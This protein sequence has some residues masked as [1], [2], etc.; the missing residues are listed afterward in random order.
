MDRTIV[1]PGALPQDTDVLSAYR[2]AMVGLG[3]L[4]A[5]TLG[6]GTVVDGLGISAST[7][8]DMNVHIAPGTIAS[9]SSV[10]ATAYGAL[11]SNAAPLVKMGINLT[12]TVLLLTAPG[13]AGQSINY[14]IQATFAETDSNA[15]VQPYYNASNPA[16]PY[17]GPS[18][19]GA[20][21]NT[22]RT[23]RVTVALKPGVAAATGSQTTPAV[24]AGYT[25]LYVVTIAN[26]QTT[27]TTANLAN[28]AIATAP[29]IPFKL[30]T[31]MNPGFSRMTVLTAGGTFIAPGGVT[32]IKVRLWAGGG[33]GGA[34]SGASSAASGGAGGG[35]A[36]GIYTVTPG[37]PG[38]TATV[39]AAGTAGTG[40]SNGGAGGPSSFGSLLSAT[41]GG[42][43]FGSAGA[44]Q[45]TAPTGGSG[46]G[47]QTNI[48]GQGGGSG[49]SA[50][51]S[52]FGGSAGGAFS[53]PGVSISSSLG[54]NGATPGGGGGGGATNSGGPGGPGLIIVEY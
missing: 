23:Q 17:S 9:L 21:Q 30:G 39:G 8:P 6:S 37:L 10:D 31:G 25:A 15:V 7:V 44:V 42:G 34:A 51:T 38:Y 47:G 40:S 49:L 28:A 27:V 52:Y 22:Q 24:D 36:E 16:V 46:T 19:T 33:G 12:E 14:L 54:G 20:P 26:G 41:G 1:Y 5:A 4:L 50:S 13:T 53:T 32:R 43:G 29:F 18:N 45:A 11:A 3:G 48:N 2:H 35:Y